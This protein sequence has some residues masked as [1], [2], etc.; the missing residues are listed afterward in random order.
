MK[1]R[2]IVVFGKVESGTIKTGEK[3]SLMPN[4]VPSQVA[5]IWNSK[6]E[7]V[8]YATPGENIKMRLLHI[9][10]EQ[11]VN[12]GDVICPMMNPMPVSDLFEAEIEI[13]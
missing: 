8:K 2:G 6:N 7:A 1:D 13:L 5:T 3:I 11:I 9:D 12:K 10:D 4:N